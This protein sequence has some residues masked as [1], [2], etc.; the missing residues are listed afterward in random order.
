[1][2]MREGQQGRE[3]N[4]H[5]ARG[6]L[7]ASRRESRDT[8]ARS[9]SPSNVRA[10]K[11]QDQARK[12]QVSSRLRDES[13]AN[14]LNARMALELEDERRRQLHDRVRRA[15]TRGYGDHAQRAYSSVSH[16]G[17]SIFSSA[18]RDGTHPFKHDLPSARSPAGRWL[19][20]YAQAARGQWAKD[21]DAVVSI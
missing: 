10:F 16:S 12:A 1:M 7:L 6:Q 8:V 9:L 3:S 4:V 20:E 14:L 15:A 18:R 2:E 19:R 11:A 5:Q 17:T 21:S 13:R